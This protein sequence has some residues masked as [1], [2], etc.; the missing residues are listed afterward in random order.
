M[1]VF[2]LLTTPA[3]TSGLPPPWSSVPGSLF[4]RLC[5]PRRVERLPLFPLRT[6]LFPHTTLPLHI[7]EER[8]KLM[9]G[10]CIEQRSPFGVVLIRSGEEAGGPAEPHEIGTTARVTQAQRLPDGKM[11][12]V[13]YGER[14]F[15]ILAL[16]TSEA[17]LQGDVELLDS[18]DGDA[19]GVAEAAA[20]VAAL[21]NE[22]LR[23]VLAISG[24]WIRRL[25]LPS[26]AATLADYV[27]GNAEL[28]QDEKQALL[29]TQSLAARLSRLAVLLSERMCV[30]SEGWEQQRREKFAGERLN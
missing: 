20:H 21:F 6:V 9:I 13:A 7:F 4:L 18:D 2:P 23:L 8:Y 29:E 14:R 25:D 24:Q 15:R 10:R 17:Y 1:L 27:A 22:H 11:N 26:N 16:D 30:L 5:Y 28:P 19:S 3:P 12:L